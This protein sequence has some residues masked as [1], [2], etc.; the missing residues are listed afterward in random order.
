MSTEVFSK[1]LMPS[2]GVVVDLTIA[3]LLF[4]SRHHEYSGSFFSTVTEHRA[5]VGLL[6][7][8]VSSALSILQ[9]FVICS[10]VNFAFRTRLFRKPTGLSALSL[11][12]AISSARIEL[13]LPLLK[14]VILCLVA[15][16]GPALAA[17]W[18][19]ALTPVLTTG[20]LATEA[21]VPVPLYPTSEYSTFVLD[22]I[23]AVRLA[24]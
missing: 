4:I 22:D 1:R 2:L 3:L 9:V 17:V 6:L 11:W 15:L 12:S 19:G 13:R 10:M 16:I 23:G 18:A 14:A 8:V 7:N 20:S 21:R 24:G 5:T